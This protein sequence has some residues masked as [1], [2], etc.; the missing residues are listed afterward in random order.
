[1][2]DFLSQ[3]NKE[4]Y[5]SKNEKKATNL[6]TSKLEQEKEDKINK[7]DSNRIKST[8]HDTEVDL[9]YHK[10]KII[11]YIL[12]AATIIF[13]SIIILIAFYLLNRVTLKNFVGLNLSEAKTWGLKNDIEIDAEMVYSIEQDEN[14]IISQDKESDSKMQKG[15]VLFLKVSKGPNQEENLSLPD[16]TQMMQS[17]IREWIDKNRAYNISITQEYS[18]QIEK[19]HFIKM[20]FKDTEVNET[21]YKRKD[22]L[23]V[24]I[25]KGSE[26]NEKNITVSD[27]KGKSKTDVESW[28]KTNS[29]TVKYEESGSDDFEKG[30]V[31]FQDI[32][33]NT[34]ISKSEILT[35]TVSLGKGLIVPN[36]ANISKDSASTTEPNLNIIVKTRYSDTVAYG[37]LMSQS[38]KSGTKLYGENKNVEVVY[39]D[40]R[41][42]MDNIVG[43]YEK[44][45][46]PYFY[47][48]TTKGA[49]ITY[50]V[51][52]V[53]SDK[54]KGMIIWTS[55]VNEY[56][57]MNTNIHVYISKGN[58]PVPN[59]TNAS[60][61]NLTNSAN[62]NEVTVNNSIF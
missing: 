13:V 52:F 59:D 12:I 39:S 19:N 57:D 43:K 1:M 61:N 5:D 15:S 24:Y 56:I 38:V 23:I 34:K 49:N 18:E 55:K 14:I 21:N 4:N 22:S 36:F 7:D 2:S 44:D 25:S 29:I 27:F 32:A 9:K 58:S 26:S 20:E 48:F 16:F 41:P 45:L 54:E 8:E 33:A 51:D 40:G 28:A 46:A 62:T 60:T 30:M 53:D 11:R 37:R 6:D 35:V 50:T 42:Y 31:I 17:Q 47:D 10:R 3:F